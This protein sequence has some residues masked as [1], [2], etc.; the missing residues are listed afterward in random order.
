M[1][2]II[3]YIRQYFS[4]NNGIVFIITSFLAA[5]FIYCN[6]SFQIEQ[7]IH[8]HDNFG[9]RVIS[10]YVVF[11]LAFTIP[12]LLYGIL[13]GRE[14][15][16]HLPFI[17]L[18]LIAPLFFAF[19]ISI[20]GIRFCPSDS[21][22]IYWRPIINWSVSLLFILAA[23]LLVWYLSKREQPFYG[24]AKTVSLKP[25]LLMLLLMLPLIVLAG[26]RPDFALIYPRLQMINDVS[27]TWWQTILFELSYGSDFFTIEL[28]FRGFLV[29]AFARWAGKDAILP[30]AL[31]YCTIHFGKP[32]GECI[33]SYFGGILLGIVVYHTRSIWGG[34]LVH[35]GIAWMMEAFG[36]FLS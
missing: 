12:Y 32:L 16:T 29:M 35:L 11:L 26:T 4:D 3:Q 10:W 17:I 8:S 30:M 15:L 18:L 2:P 13:A 5:V 23:L 1:R 34:L 28:F 7:Q 25:Y 6:Y 33:S 22:T 21:T 9:I 14:Y 27:P 24:M 31:F 19:R 36:F 20:P